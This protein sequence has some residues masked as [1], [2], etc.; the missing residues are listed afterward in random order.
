[1]VKSKLSPHSGSVALRQLKPIVF[2]YIHGKGTKTIPTTEAAGAAGNKANKKIMFKNC[3]PFTKCISE[4]NNT[5]V[6]D[7]HNIDVVMSMY[8]L[9]EYSVI[10]S[11]ASGGLRQYYKNELALCDKGNII[12]FP[13]NRN[14]NISFRFKQQIAGKKGK[15]STKHFEIMVS[16]KYLNNFSS[17]AIN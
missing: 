5:Q 15:Y 12:D 9:T 4:M 7:A 16:L 8:D 10:Y 14:N 3:A 11:K 1:M 2:F 6:D 13:G 17:N